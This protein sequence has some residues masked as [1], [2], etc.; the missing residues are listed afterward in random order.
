MI[1]ETSLKQQ[2]SKA[3]EAIEKRKLGESI[4]SIKKLIQYTGLSDVSNL[5]RQVD[6]NYRMMLDYMSKGIADE[7]REAYYTRFLQ[8]MD[9]CCSKL[10]RSIELGS[11]ISNYSITWNTL[12]N[13]KIELQSIHENI[14]YRDLFDVIWTSDMWDEQD[15]III[16]NLLENTEY[17]EN[18]KCLILSATMLAALTFFDISKIR[19]L[20]K[21]INS[22]NENIRARAIVGF[23]LVFARYQSK[24]DIY[25]ELKETI[26]SLA[27]D[28]DLSKDL[29]NLQTQIF[30]SLDTPQIEKKVRDE[31]L[32]SIL[33]ES[34]HLSSKKSFGRDLNDVFSNMDYELSWDGMG[35]ELNDKVKSLVDLQRKGADVFIGQFKLVKQSF[36]FFNIAANWFYPFTQS[37][38]EFPTKLSNKS[39]ISLIEK[40]N[41]LCDSDKYSFCL[42]IEQ[43]K[44]TDGLCL[45]DTDNKI[46]NFLD[47][48]NSYTIKNTESNVMQDKIHSYMLDV[49]RFFYFFRK[50]DEKVNPFKEDLFIAHWKIWKDVFEKEP[51]I[52]ILADFA[53]QMKNF[54]WAV[55][56]YKMC[57]CDTEEFRKI[58]YCYQKM[59]QYSK[60]LDFYSKSDF[61]NPNQSW[62]LMRLGNCSEK[63]GDYAEAQVYYEQ[64]EHISP[65]NEETLLRLGACLMKQNELSSALKKFYKA[66]YLNPNSTSIVRYIAWCCLHSHKYEQSEKF[67]VKLLKNNPKLEDWLYAGHEAWASGNI[68]TAI[69]RYVHY[70]TDSSNHDS[71]GLFF[72]HNYDI[73]NKFNINKTD[74]EL[75]QDILN[76]KLQN[77]GNS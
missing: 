21:C 69:K 5:L 74:I 3:I 23:T 55:E 56:L 29:I 16:Q 45:G 50:R 54:S 76:I 18:R 65:N 39:I 12:Q 77:N 7:Q 33:K 40:N 59:G 10:C 15:V 17:D 68:A 61:L 14:S 63:L 47:G 6:C 34:Q 67:Y 19:L 25:P 24:Y 43:M 66:Y 1:K 32:P 72:E 31:I 38:P 20:L 44:R 30:L 46:E 27:A 11:P 36:P 48:N 2:I 22:S 62:T 42:I 49:Y 9:Y 57:K 13:M 51:D 52:L 71:A 8:Q 35:E 41:T 73:L 4:K 53:F 60:A 64:V 58:G 28:S 70:F 75:M 26:L 37:H